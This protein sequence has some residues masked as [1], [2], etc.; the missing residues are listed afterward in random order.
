M[1]VRARQSFQ[2]F[3]QIIWFLES[4]GALPKSKGTLMQI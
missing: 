1:V 3:R 2:V 4:N